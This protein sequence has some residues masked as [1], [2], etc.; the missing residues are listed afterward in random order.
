MRRLGRDIGG[1]RKAGIVGRGGGRALAM[2][3]AL[4]LAATPIFAPAVWASDP[5][6]S[7]DLERLRKEIEES[8]E[9]VGSHEQQERNL[10]EILEE[11]DRTLDE[12]RQQV[13]SARERADSAR[14][15]LA[16]VEPRL[17]EV[18]GALGRTRSAMSKRVVALYR[19]GEVGP[20]RMLFAS[21]SLPDLLSRMASL[22]R[23]L[24]HDAR[25]VARF[26]ERYE[27]LQRVEVEAAEASAE[28][29]DASARLAGH[30][31]D[32]EREKSMQ[33]T[34]LASVRG[35]RTQERELLVELERAARALEET[36]ANLGESD[37]EMREM[38]DGAGFS[39]LRGRLRAPVSG[40]IQ[41]EFGRVVDEEYRTETFSKG[42]EFGA[43][44]GD[45]VK[46]VARGQVRYAGWFRGYGKIVIVDHGD[47]F[48]TV[49]GHLADVFVEVGDPVRP[50]DTLGTVGDTG[51]L[52]G[53]AL[54]FEIRAGGEP[55]DPTKWLRRGGRG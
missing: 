44:A 11:I 52:S 25:L 1:V 2:S 7:Q 26:S 12:M 29:Q 32:L 49:S 8:R 36:L 39:N 42:V 9:R 34:T 23:L 54:Y 5:L 16:D 43:K 14:V 21:E 51:S 6:P 41:Q 50:G 15:A 17:H 24:Q 33:R 38:L 46:A 27:R 28:M 53:P 40:R 20:L 47:A 18:R 22:E 30:H 48:F 37:H 35:N 4:L 3:L 10:L 19:A 55:L 45:S 31:T 13:A